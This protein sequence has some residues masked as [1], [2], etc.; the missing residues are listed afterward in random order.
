MSTLYY[1][2][3]NQQAEAFK[4][5]PKSL[6]STYIW[7]FYDKYSFFLVF[8]FRKN[9]EFI[10]DV[11]NASLQDAKTAIFPYIKSIKEKYRCQDTEL[12]YCNESSTLI[13]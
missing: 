13:F 10:T 5:S 7:C 2:T 8:S 11:R 6:I 1:H 9:G 4:M 3:H 12:K